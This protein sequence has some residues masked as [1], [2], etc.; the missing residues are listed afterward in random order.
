MQNQVI[1]LVFKA[2]DR[3]AFDGIDVLEVHDLYFLP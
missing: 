2:A 1:H 3:V